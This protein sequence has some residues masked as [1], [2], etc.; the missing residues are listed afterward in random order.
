MPTVELPDATI[1][2][3]LWGKGPVVLGVM[4]FGL[5][6]R[7]WASQVGAITAR[8]SF[9]TFDNR[10]I[11]R[12]KERP[13]TTI[14]D[15]AADAL[16]VLDHLQ[17]DRTVV[18]GASMGGAI[19]QRLALEQPDRVAGLVLAVTWAR[20]VEFM[21]RQHEVARMIIESHGPRALIDASIV[22][23]FTPRFFEA[24]SEAIDRMVAAFYAPD[25]PGLPRREA[26]LAQL[27]AIDKHDALAELV[28]IRCP[29]L[30][31]GGKMDV[32]A[33]FFASEEI[34]RAI[35]GAELA[36]FETGHACLI[37]EMQ[38]VNDRVSGFLGAL[39]SW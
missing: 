36:A 18:F 13:S 30:V 21:R 8:N 14:E 27:D 20:P 4:G 15:M 11:G 39:G 26:L 12:S 16:V 38:A 7:F 17:V 29:A 24:G 19:A 1:H 31:L 9:I 5:D 33:P 2:Y 37:E 35:P 23:M 22:R 28:R 34:A 32:M 6:Q 25:G 3:K 10:G